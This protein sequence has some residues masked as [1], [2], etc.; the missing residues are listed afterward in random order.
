MFK[1]WNREG[2][3]EVEKEKEGE[4]AQGL[5]KGC[6]DGQRLNQGYWF[7]R[8][9]SGKRPRARQSMKGTRPVD[10]ETKGKKASRKME[11]GKVGTASRQE[12]KE[13]G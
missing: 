12:G 2:T 9:G 5:P 8:P 1:K 7:R 10:R 3:P 11:K 13:E 4:L 6:H